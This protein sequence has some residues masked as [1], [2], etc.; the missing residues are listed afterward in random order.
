MIYIQIPAFLEDKEESRQLKKMTNWA[1][2]K[3]IEN[4]KK[5][6]SKY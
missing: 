6:K 3:I 5:V 1:K 2:R 4:P